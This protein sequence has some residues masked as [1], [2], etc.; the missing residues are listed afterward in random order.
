MPIPTELASACA[1]VT[2][3]GEADAIAGRQARYVAAPASTGEASAL[4]RAAAA[5]GLTVVPRG[6]G[7]LQHWGNPPDSCDLIVDTRRLDRI[8][9]HVT[10]D[11]TVTVQAG[12]RLRDLEQA[13]E[14]GGQTLALLVPGPA[15]AGTVGGL[16]AT[17]AAGS[18]RYRH[19][20]PRDRLTGI[21]AVRADGTIVASTGAANVAGQDLV[22]LLAGSYGSLGLIT[23]ATFR[24]EPLPQVL[25][26][27]AL[28]CTDPEHAERLVE[29]VR[30]PWIAA[31]GID[32]RWPSADQPLRLFVKIQGDRED[33]RAR[34]ERLHA[35][36]GRPAPPPIDRA[37]ARRLDD[38]DHGGIPPALAQELLAERDRIR[39]EILDPPADTGTLV[40]VSFPPA[41]LAGTL[42]L[43]RS[44]AAGSGV[45][46]AIGG[47][48]GAGVLD[49][50]VPVGSP[51]AAV[52][53]F[54]DA[55]R[56]DLGRLSQP[57]TAPGSVRAV[58]VYAPDEVRDLAD[59]HGPVPSLALLRAVKDEFDP[60]HRM[61]PG[62]LADAV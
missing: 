21:T 18:R 26:D 47:S 17:N 25:G 51:P 27:V 13:V 3:A 58:V 8:V 61:A 12:V 5:L 11:F 41:R 10:A 22:T 29:E 32:L 28:N 16:I 31:I 42:T 15:Y 46:A 19:G 30:D 23:E 7:R 37:R 20:T 55:L 43:I 24:L 48:A 33:F 50:K 14:A 39:A 60:E 36:A 54:V 45:D 40:R 44:A 62:R 49:V 57:G 59:T 53:R 34:S 38:P 2:L 52:A 1:D 6:A 56:A 4:L 9:E 35:L